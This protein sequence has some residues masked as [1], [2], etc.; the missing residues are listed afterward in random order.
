[1]ISATGSPAK[2]SVRNTFNPAALYLEPE[3][4][5]RKLGVSVRPVSGASRVSGV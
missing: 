3:M 2:V 5:P 1:M 4:P